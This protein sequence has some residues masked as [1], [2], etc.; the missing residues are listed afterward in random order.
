MVSTHNRV[1]YYWSTSSI[2]KRLLI[3]FDTRLSIPLWARENKQNEPI[4]PIT[5][6]VNRKI[7]FLQTFLLVHWWLHIHMGLTLE[8]GLLKKSTTYLFDHLCSLFI[9]EFKLSKCLIY[10]HASYLEWKSQEKLYLQA[11]GNRRKNSQY[12]AHS[13][14]NLINDFDLCWTANI[15]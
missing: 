8:N 7:C 5:N 4:K 6:R 2:W 10:A 11:I 12:K 9:N 13:E 1:A 15:F 14:A 3:L